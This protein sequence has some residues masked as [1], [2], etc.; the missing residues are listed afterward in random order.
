MVSFPPTFP[1]RLFLFDQ[2]LYLCLYRSISYSN[3]YL[4]DPGVS[5]QSRGARR[6]FHNLVDECHSNRCTKSCANI[7]GSP[8][9]F[10][11][12]CKCMTQFHRR[13]GKSALSLPPPGGPPAA[14]RADAGWVKHLIY[15]CGIRS[16][17]GLQQA[18]SVHRC[19]SCVWF[20]S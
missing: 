13:G 11:K 16:L 2:F 9:C 4:L 3:D 20:A 10:R 6:T 17:K 5:H 1:R 8:E 19:S 12:P 7:P 14:A 15:R 18:A